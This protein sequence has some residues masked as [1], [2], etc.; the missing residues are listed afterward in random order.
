[1]AC[2]STLWYG[3]DAKSFDSERDWA[4]VAESA[5]NEIPV[6]IDLGTTFSVVSS[7]DSQGRPYTIQNAEGDVTTPS[8][9]MFDGSN[10]I[11][12]KEAVKLASYEPDAVAAYAKR[13]HWREADRQGG[14]RQ[15][16]ASGSRRI[17][18]PLEAK[19]RRRVETWTDFQR[20]HHRPGILQ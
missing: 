5:S 19:D 3:N 4:A 14:Q 10:V 17:T 20:G 11:V 6:G 2:C 15:S 7:L 8:V 9:V 1:M 12:G 18:G 13:E 16:S